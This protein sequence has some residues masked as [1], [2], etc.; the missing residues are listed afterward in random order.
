M[1]AISVDKMPLKAKFKCSTWRFKSTN[2]NAETLKESNA[3]LT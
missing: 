2:K 3:N 1:K